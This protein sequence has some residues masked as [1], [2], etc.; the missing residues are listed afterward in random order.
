MCSEEDEKSVSGAEKILILF[1]LRTAGGG[2]GSGEEHISIRTV[3]G[4]TE[5]D[6]WR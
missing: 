3:I 6:I 1:R 5:T 2:C 4:G